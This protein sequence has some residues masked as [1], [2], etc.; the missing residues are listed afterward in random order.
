[1]FETSGGIPSR[2]DI[3]DSKL[4]IIKPVSYRLLEL[5]IGKTELDARETDLAVRPAFGEELLV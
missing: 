4:E 1:M 3:V 5:D 2:K